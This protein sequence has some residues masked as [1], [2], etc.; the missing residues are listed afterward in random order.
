MKLKFK[1]IFLVLFVVFSFGIYSGNNIGSAQFCN[2]NPNDP[3]FIYQC[4]A[5]AYCPEGTTWDGSSCI[6]DPQE[7][8]PCPSGQTRNSRG[9]C[10][11]PPINTPC[12]SPSNSCGMANQGT[13]V[14]GTCSA[15][16]PYS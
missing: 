4:G 8:P 1:I 3:G 9:D 15:S 16:T 11:A 2:G 7:V 5:A 14:N 13:V 6:L 12:T 10:E